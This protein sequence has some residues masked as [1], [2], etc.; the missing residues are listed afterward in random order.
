MKKIFLITLFFV[1]NNF[2][3]NN[4]LDNYIKLGL[5]NNLT[6]KQKKFS[7][8]QSIAALDEARGMFFPSIGI[9][10]RYSRAG[11]GREINFPVGTLFNPIYRTLNALTHSNQFP[12]NL[13]NIT[14]PFLREKEHDTKLS[15]VLPIVQ[16]ALFYNY[17]IKSDLRKIKEIE[18]NI[19]ERKLIADIKIAY[20][21]YLKSIE[22]NKLFKNTIKLVEENLRVSKSLY[23][24]DKVTIDVLYRAKAEVSDVKQKQIEAERNV[25]LAKSYFN[26]L[27][28]KPLESKI[29]IFADTVNTNKLPENDFETHALLNREEL[30]QVKLAVDVAEETAKLAKSKYLPGLVLAVDYGFQGEEYKFT[31]D[32]DYWMA[33]LVLRWNLFNGFQDKAK[34][35]QAELEAK[36]LF[37]QLT[38]VKN[39]IRLQVKEALKNYTVAA[40]TIKATKERLESFRKSFKIVRKKYAEGMASQIEYLDARNRLTQAE[41][42]AIIAQYDFKQKIAVLE[43]V[44][45]LIELKK[46]E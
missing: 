1:I 45:A 17:G 42:Q 40:K 36:K 15:L 14:F 18:K 33:S 27:I 12:T 26:F 19:Y 32:D 2:A 7:L 39:Q 13:Q 23:K 4:I 3:Q 41:V 11:G 43:Q 6:L 25:E 35:E 31:E 30:S 37:A 21:N 16:P 10:A 22:V 28:N 24:N 34:K 20:Y 9:N 29:E 5:K 46:Y 44:V 8:K 38:E